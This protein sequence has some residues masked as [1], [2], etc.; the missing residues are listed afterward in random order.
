MAV[1]LRASKQGLEKVDKARKNKGW[2]ANAT[3]WC[4]EANTTVATL[5]RFRRGIPVERETFIS[6]CEAVGENWQ[7]IFDENPLPQVTATA[8]FF[9]YDEAWVGREQLITQLKDKVEGAC[10]VLILTGITGIGKTALAERLAVELYPSWLHGDWRKL[11]RENFD[12]ENQISDFGSV[13]AKWLEK[14]GQPVTPEERKDTRRLLNRLVKRLQERRYLVLIDSLEKILQ[15]NEE[16]G[17][18]D[19]QDEWWLRFFQSLLTVE[20]CQSRIVLTSQD[21]PAQIPTIGTRYQNFWY[22]QPLTG[23]EE[24]E[25]LALFDKTG[26]EVEAESPGMPY[27]VRIGAAYEGHPLALRVIAG[28]IGNKPFSG[29]VVAYWNKYGQEVEEVEKAIEEAK[30]KGITASADDQWQ[31]HQYTRELRRHVRGRLETTFGRLKA[32]VLNAYRLLCEASVYRCPV[33]EEFWLSH[34]EDWDCDERTQERALEALQ[35]RYLVEEVVEKEQFL[36][37]QHNLIR[38]VALEHL[39]QLDEEE[40]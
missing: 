23:L 2:R 6:I 9:A 20:S 16:E 28:E 11:V 37:R 7:E 5:K 21:M 34:L 8:E 38:S 33:P 31:L 3:A 13:A 40:E 15:G 32:D 17:W 14:W 35:D 24:P 12:N 27:L 10:R 26:L 22:C 29:N 4:D 36:L 19:F 25:Q 30:T 39:K 18:N 1:S